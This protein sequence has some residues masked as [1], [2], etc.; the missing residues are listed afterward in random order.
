MLLAKV[1]LSLSQVTSLSQMPLSPTYPKL[2]LL[3][4]PPPT[5]CIS[6][7]CSKH[8]YTLNLKLKIQNTWSLFLQLSLFSKDFLTKVDLNFRVNN[9][10]I[11]PFLFILFQTPQLLF[12]HEETKPETRIWTSDE[13]QF[14]GPWKWSQAVYQGIEKSHYRVACQVQWTLVFMPWGI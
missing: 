3:S 12:L 8:Q 14:W 1:L 9:I 7:F 6:E 10:H 5:P 11:H 4:Y 13:E 2:D